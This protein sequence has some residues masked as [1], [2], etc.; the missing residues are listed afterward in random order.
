MKTNENKARKLIVEAF[1]NENNLYDFATYLSYK[2]YLNHPKV[3]LE[4]L[5]QSKFAKFNRSNQDLYDKFLEDTKEMTIH[6][7]RSS[8]SES[9]QYEDTFTN[10]IKQLC[11][12]CKR[13]SKLYSQVVKAS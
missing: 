9:V 11:S 2:M 6:I 1:K 7:S 10:Y 12:D 8:R 3:S 5:E 13:V 4:Q